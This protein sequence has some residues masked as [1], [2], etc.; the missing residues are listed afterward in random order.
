MW[1]FDGHLDL[2]W[3]AIDYKRDL[4]ASVADIR[5]SEQGRTEPSYGANTVSIPAMRG[6]RI[7]VCVA[8]LLARLHRPGNPMFGYATAEACYAVAKGQLAY[9]EAMQRAGHFRILSTRGDL[10]DHVRQF[11]ECP[12]RVLSQGERE[13]TPPIGVILSMEGADPVLDPANIREWHHAGLRAIGL[14]HYGLNRYGGGTASEEGL[15]P[16]APALLKEIEKLGMPIDLTHLSDKAFWEAVKLFDGRV[17]ASHQ[18]SRALV[19]GQRQ[20]SD[21][22]IRIVID[23]DGVI[24]AAFDAW[25]LQPDYVRGQSK[26][27]VTLESVADH[28]D[29]VC[30][31]AG[32]GRHSALG[33]DLDGGF[34]ADQ[35]PRGLDTIADLRKICHILARRGYSHEDMAAIVHGNW[36]RFFRECLP[37]R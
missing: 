9:Y 29:H 2:A 17:L 28:I 34:G 26:P 37:A 8:T 15:A 31:L 14:T 12:R 20:F 19:S 25:M 4:L 36:L 11:E 1:I 27:T 18:N 22:Q 13:A 35:C 30:Q 10:D 32:N 33:T 16:Q 7:G 6:A 23:R 3:N 21:E 5:A 24:G